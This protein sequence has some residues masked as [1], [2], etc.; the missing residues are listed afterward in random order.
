LKRLCCSDADKNQVTTIICS[1]WSDH[2]QYI[3]LLLDKLVNYKIL[4]PIDVVTFVFGVIKMTP[5]SVWV[6]PVLALAFHKLIHNEEYRKEQQLS[7]EKAFLKIAIEQRVLEDDTMSSMSH[8]QH[9]FL[10]WLFHTLLHYPE[11]IP[12]LK[13]Q[14]FAQSVP[15]AALIFNQIQFVSS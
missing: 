7:D 10:E 5:Q 13:L 9:P 3:E 11:S 1:Y 15:L 2:S 14:D 12:I 6:W 8:D 4:T